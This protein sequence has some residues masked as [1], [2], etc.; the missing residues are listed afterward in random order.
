M[1]TL[2]NDLRYALRMLGKSPLVTGAAFV[3][4]A[5]GIGANSAMFSW[6]YNLML[7]PLGVVS[8]SAPMSLGRAF[9]RTD[10]L[11]RSWES[12]PRATASPRQ[13]RGLV[14]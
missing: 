7:D 9:G 5:L 2:M 3:S 13:R 8:R 11:S 6:V 12:C 1:D 14:R 4:L 10:I